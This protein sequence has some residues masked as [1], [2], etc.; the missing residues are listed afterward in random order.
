MNNEL[1]QQFRE[2]EVAVI[3]FWDK[4]RNEWV[5]NVFPKIGGRL[6]LAHEQNE[7]ISIETEIY[8]YDE[9]LAVVIGTCRTAKGCFK[10]IGMSSVQ[11]DQR[12]APAILELAETRSIARALRF[13]GFGVEYCSAEEVSHL[14]TATVAQ[15]REGNNSQPTTNRQI[16]HQTSALPAPTNTEPLPQEDGK[17]SEIPDSDNGNMPESKIGKVE[18]SFQPTD[19]SATVYRPQFKT[20]ETDAPAQEN[21][22]G[23]GNARRQMSF[24]QFEYIKSMGKKLGFDLVGLSQKS[25]EIFNRELPYLTVSEA[26]TFIDH[27]QAGL[28]RSNNTAV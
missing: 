26:S 20:Y 21:G 16:Q 1:K 10:G 25:I 13:A 15:P 14:E 6:R 4:S 19:T 18:I 28:F 23:N 8:R 24:K 22:N 3:R 2:D 7:A 5:S 17:P 11:R 12:I 27:M 9:N